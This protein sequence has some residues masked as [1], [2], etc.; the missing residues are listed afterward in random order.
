MVYCSLGFAFGRLCASFL[1][2]IAIIIIIVVPRSSSLSLLCKSVR[3]V[4][5]L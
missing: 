4:C 2:I 1:Y 3:E 5:S